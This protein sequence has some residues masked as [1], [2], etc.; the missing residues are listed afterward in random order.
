MPVRTSIVSVLALFVLLPAVNA[1]G[2][3]IVS[4]LDAG[5]APE[6]SVFDFGKTGQQVASFFAYDPTFA[7]GVRVA[8]GDVHGRRRRRH[9][10]RARA[11][12]PGRTSR[13]STARTGATGPLVLRLRPG[14]TGGVFVAAGDV[15]GDGNADI[16]V[17]AGAGARPARQGVRRRNEPALLQSFF[18]YDALRRRRARRR[19][20]RERRRP[21]RHHHRRRP[22]GGAHVK[23]F[24]GVDRCLRPSSPT[25]SF[26]GGV[27]V[28]AGDVNGDGKADIITGAGPGS[29][30]A[31]K[32][33]DGATN[34][35]LAS[36]FAFDGGFNGGVRVAAGDVNGDGIADMIVAAG[37]G[38]GPHVKAFKGDDPGVLLHSF[39]AAAP[40]FNGGV[41]VA[42]G[43]VEHVPP[44][45]DGKLIVLTRQVQVAF[46]H[47]TELLLNAA[48][49][50]EAGKVN[51][52]CGMLNAFQRR[53]A[54]QSGKQLSS[55]QARHFV[56]SAQN[57]ASTLECR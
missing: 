55:A 7:G 16:I 13:C 22:T 52:A 48:S 27:Y 33:F 42:A 50:M 4:G 17:G 41:F 36:F 18:A 54:A 15:N 53:A 6:V 5:G 14:F 45:P 49:Q 20:R 11:P 8:A 25:A 32:A 26:H 28:A 1:H 12:A 40:S 46:P 39:L 29:R 56:S 34:A 38:A 19:G 9:R 3:S 2:Q 23:V 51:G 35:V 44:T 24:D 47:A 31:R 10:D 21:R 43:D 30:P 57:I 37:P